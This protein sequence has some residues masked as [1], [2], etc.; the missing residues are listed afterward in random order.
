MKGFKW[1]I[2][3]FSYLQFNFIG[4]VIGAA[5]SLIGGRSANKSREKAT[6]Q[7]NAQTQASTREQMAFQERSQATQMAFQERMSNTAHQR[8]MADLKSAGLNPILAAQNPASSPGGSAMPGASYQA[9]TPQIHDYITPAVNTGLQA[10]QA[11]AQVNQIN[12][13]IEKTIQETSNLKTTQ[14]LTKEQIKQVGENIHVLQETVKKITAETSLAEAKSEVAGV[15]AAFVDGGGLQD[16]ARQAA[17]SQK[18]AAT[19]IGEALGKG[20]GATHVFVRELWHDAT[21]KLDSWKNPQNFI[22]EFK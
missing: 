8:A 16:L 10:Y 1:L 22:D 4:A 19:I 13:G 3:G 17:I 6:A 15:F 21:G 2:F 12:A 14:G 7:A 9:Q 20:A 11:E 18:Q 5:A